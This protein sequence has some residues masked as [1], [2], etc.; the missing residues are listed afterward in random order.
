M[1][2]HA[3]K[4]KRKL[5]HIVVVHFVDDKGIL[6][7]FRY[8]NDVALNKSNPDVRVNFLE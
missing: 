4:T 3:Y 6:H 5:D 2:H 7:Q 8:I 1:V